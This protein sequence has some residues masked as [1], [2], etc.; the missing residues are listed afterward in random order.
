MDLKIILMCFTIASI[1]LF[2]DNNVTKNNKAQIVVCQQ[3]VRV[4]ANGQF[5]KRVP[6]DCYFEKCSE[7]SKKH[8]EPSVLQKFKSF[9]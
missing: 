3:D 4:C 9:F 8:D 2:A 5:A 1:S 6:P 7:I